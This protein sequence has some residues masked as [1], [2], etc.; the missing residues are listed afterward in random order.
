ME[1]INFAEI[2]ACGEN[3]SACR[4]KISGICKGCI[5]SDGYVPEWSESGRCPVHA[6]C[7]E[8]DVRFCG[9]CAEFPCAKLPGLVRWNPDIVE[10]QRTLAERFRGPEGLSECECAGGEENFY[11]ESRIFLD[12]VVSGDQTKIRSPYADALKTQRL[13]FAAMAALR[14]GQTVRL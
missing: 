8:H 4:K 3:C 12:A 10:Q 14:D 5:E 1:K 7:R 13:T 9:L 6:C 2:T 11:K